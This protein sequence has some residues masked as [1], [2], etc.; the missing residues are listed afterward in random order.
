MS[1]WVLWDCSGSDH[2]CASVLQEPGLVQVLGKAGTS[3]GLGEHLLG[4]MQG[5]G[6]GP[7]LS[8]MSSDFWCPAGNCCQGNWLGRHSSFLELPITFRKWFPLGFTSCLQ[9]KGR[10]GV[11]LKPCLQ[12]CTLD[13][14]QHS[15]I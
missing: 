7:R 14:S 13:A 10:K 11:L 8:R 9:Q 4:L 15:Q 5:D 12:V 2:G 3:E 1:P 6:S